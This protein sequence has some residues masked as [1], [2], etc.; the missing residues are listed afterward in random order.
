VSP[1]TGTSTTSRENHEKNRGGTNPWKKCGKKWERKEN[2]AKV[3]ERVVVKKKSIPK[4][5]VIEN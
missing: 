2:I 4:S 5:K 1:T 3:S